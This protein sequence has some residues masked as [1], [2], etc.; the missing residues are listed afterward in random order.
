MATHSARKK[1]L[2]LSDNDGLSRV[3]ELHL[4]S[5]TL[6]VVRQPLYSSKTK[7]ENAAFDLI[8]VALSSPT[9]D[10]GT[11]L[12]RLNSQAEQVPV[13]IISEQPLLT[14]PGDWVSHLDFPFEIDEFYDRVKEM[15]AVRP[16]HSNKP[17]I[18][19]TFQP[20]ISPT[21]PS[22]VLDRGRQAE[23]WLG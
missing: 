13:L 8:V 2:V 22:E 14:A 1:V 9:N 15:L 12:S 6:E 5:R 20:G 11:M 16:I 3:M 7:P 18:P 23:Y 17:T 19:K 21:R 10:P 4:K